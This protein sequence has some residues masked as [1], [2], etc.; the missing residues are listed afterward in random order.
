MLNQCIIIITQNAFDVYLW[1]TLIRRSCRSGQTIYPF[2]STFQVGRAG[3]DT[4]EV[5]RKVQNLLLEVE[6]I[7]S[8]LENS[9]TLDEKDI[10]RLEEQIRI[11]EDKLK[12]TKLEEKL[13]QLQKDHKTRNELIEQYKLEIA[14]LQNEVDNIEEV[15]EALPE[16]C[17]RRLELEP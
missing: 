15:I 10:D 1:L 17:F 13:E 2:I 7:M 16:G 12:E 6:E 11:T 9:P 8:E 14:W 4:D 3:K 5:S